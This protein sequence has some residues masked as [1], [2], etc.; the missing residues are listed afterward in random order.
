[1]GYSGNL[2]TYTFLADDETK[3]SGFVLEIVLLKV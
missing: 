3:K 2:K 1:M